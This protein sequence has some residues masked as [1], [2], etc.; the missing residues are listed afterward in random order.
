V[1]LLGFGVAL[2]LG[3]TAGIVPA[4]GAYRSRITEMLRTV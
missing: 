4:V 2:A 3:F 1:A